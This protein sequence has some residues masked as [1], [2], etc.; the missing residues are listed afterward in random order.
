M[1]RSLQPF[2]PRSSLTCLPVVLAC[3]FVT[4]TPIAVPAQETAAEKILNHADIA[5]KCEPDRL[6]VSNNAGGCCGAPGRRLCSHLPSCTDP[7]D[8]KARVDPYSGGVWC[9]SATSSCSTSFADSQQVAQAKNTPFDVSFYVTSDVHF[10]RTSFRLPD[11]VRHV[12]M[13]N[14][15]HGL[16]R[17]WPASIGFPDSPFPRPWGVLMA[18]DLTLEGKAEE[19]GAYRLLYEPGTTADSIVYPVF[20]GLGNHDI[21]LTNGNSVS[22]MF[23]YI[24]KS[25]GCGVDVDSVSHSYSWDWNQLHI[26]QL[27]V[28]AGFESPAGPVKSGL[29]WLAQDLANRV[30]NSG[31]PVLIIQHAGCD[32]LSIG[33]NTN[34]GATDRTP[35]TCGDADGAKNGLWTAAN[36][37]TFFN[38]IRHYNVIGLFTG[39]THAAEI[40]RAWELKDSS[41]NPVIRLDNFVN[42]AGGSNG[43]GIVSDAGH[44][45]FY[46]VRVTG[47]YLDVVPIQW[48]D[49]PSP[50]TDDQ[51]RDQSTETSRIDA[52]THVSPG[53]KFG[54]PGCRKRI[55]DRFIAVPPSQ[56]RLAAAGALVSVTN[57]GAQAIPGDLALRILG[58]TS[59]VSFVDSCVDE[60]AE[61]KSYV[62]ITLLPPFVLAPGGSVL[63]NAGVPFD[64][65]KMELVVLTPIQGASTKLVDISVAPQTPVPPGS[66]TFYGP[67]ST[68]YSA[69]VLGDGGLG[70][71]TVTPANGSFDFF[72]H[73][74]LNYVVN[75]SKLSPQSTG[76]LGVDIQMSTFVPDALGK[77]YSLTVGW[78]LHYKAPVTIQLT[79]TPPGFA[80]TTEPHV[81]FTAV[82]SHPPVIDTTSPKDPFSVFPA[83]QVDLVELQNGFFRSVLSKA[84][85]GDQ[86]IQGG[87]GCNTYPQDTVVFGDD[88]VH[89]YCPSQNPS[90]PD[91]WK[92]SLS[93]GS[94]TLFASYGGDPNY[95]PADSPPIFYRVGEPAASIV[96][97][98][99]GGQT[100]FTGVR[101][102]KPITL[103]VLDAS[104]HPLSGVPV[105]ITF[106][107]TG[108]SALFA[109]SAVWS[110]FTDVNGT[111]VSSFPSANAI[112][113]SH[114]GVARVTEAGSAVT[115]PFQMT[116]Q[117]PPGI[118]PA[119]TASVFSKFPEP[120]IS[121]TQRAW[122][123]LFRNSGGP[124][125]GLQLTQV[126]FTQE[127]GTPC[128][129]DLK[130]FVQQLPEALLPLLTNQDSVLG[131]LDLNFAG[132]AA[133]SRFTVTVGVTANGGGYNTLI[134]IPHQF[135]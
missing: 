54:Q 79:A 50:L 85:L 17:T 2:Q 115:L 119:I 77:P 127:A 113:G 125:H 103:R 60:G 121:P 75:L 117:A 116:N 97:T 80:R 35:T 102:D 110:G 19:L 123:V 10:F 133:N 93:R 87:S 64:P 91:A 28:W 132:C 40:H 48:N 42:G 24:Q 46:A 106:G 96:L 92:F 82:L 52:S 130:P 99:G 6:D 69:Q 45:E 25:M 108:A 36:R 78:S 26:I 15:F 72:G 101:F 120:V 124:A 56:Y 58:P 131:N 23:D 134:V 94:H 68:P 1:T 109:G 7:G 83:G 5:L 20:Q 135:Q 53:F 29:P 128:A 70:W 88:G 122:S 3:L 12:R 9:E 104:S 100:T 11:Q 37:Q 73:A 129:P 86:A 14:E 4:L 39:H 67:P 41:G 32:S 47:S 81:G 111:A 98:D 57:I 62:L 16:R 30:G 22:R 51:R 114:S 27:N 95:Q 8:N 21:D 84:F 13:M 76:A 18:G 90:N 66:I 31:R 71:L 61:S 112:T 55:G 44:G 38:V 43:S 63:V 105:S 89:N 49:P 126:L 33:T 34:N 65:D 59:Q 74:T 118:A 107:S